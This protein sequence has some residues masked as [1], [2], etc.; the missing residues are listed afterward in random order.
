M[1]VTSHHNISFINCC[2]CPNTQPLLYVFWSRF[3]AWYAIYL[4]TVL[5]GIVTCNMKW[6]SNIYIASL[7][8]SLTGF[9]IYLWRR[10]GCFPTFQTD[11]IIISR[12]YI[13]N[14]RFSCYCTDKFIFCK[15]RNMRDNTLILTDESSL[16]NHLKT[17]ISKFTLLQEGI[18]WK[19]FSNICQMWTK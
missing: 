15:Y 6:I 16:A 4:C 9:C 13:L 18:T 1:G 3:L 12:R 19:L 5:N 7:K 17:W 8:N 14:V 11:D 10:N 2:H